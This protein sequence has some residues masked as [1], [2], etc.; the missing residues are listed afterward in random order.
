MTSFREWWAY[1]MWTTSS[2]ARLINAFESLQAA[3]CI[4]VALIVLTMSLKHEK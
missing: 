1:M 3:C 4:I 2:I